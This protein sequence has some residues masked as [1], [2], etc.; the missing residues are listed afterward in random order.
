M[1]KKT[2]FSKFM[3]CPHGQGGLSQCGRFADKEGWGQFFAILCGRLLW[4]APKIIGYKVI[5]L[6]C[7]HSMVVPALAKKQMTRMAITTAH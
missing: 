1:R 2:D 6:H 7:I 4:T 3:V 5:W